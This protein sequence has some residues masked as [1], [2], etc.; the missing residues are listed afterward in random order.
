[1]KEGLSKVLDTLS[2]TSDQQQSLAE[3]FNQID[4][5]EKVINELEKKAYQ[6][7]FYSKKLENTFK[8]LDKSNW[9]SP[10]L[11]NT[12][13]SMRDLHEISARSSESALGR[14]SDL[15]NFEGAFGIKWICDPTNFESCPLANC[16][17]IWSLLEKSVH[18]VQI[19]TDFLVTLSAGFTATVKFFSRFLLFKQLLIASHW[20]CKANK[21]CIIF[22]RK[23]LIFIAVRLLSSL[24]DSVE[25]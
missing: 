19:Y 17:P 18:F 16:S 6:I 10:L 13:Q 22:L 8:Q 20:L 11:L 23:S 2:E 3:Y 7:D 5:L 14:F 9:V 21:L 12:P 15:T 4:H 25:L 1:M 24:S